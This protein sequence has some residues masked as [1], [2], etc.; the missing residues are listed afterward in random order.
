MYILYNASQNINEYRYGFARVRIIGIRISKSLLYC[1]GTEPSVLLYIGILVTSTTTGPGGSVV[2][3]CWTEPSLSV[4]IGIL[5]TS[6]TTGP[7]I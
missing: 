7:D 3:P 1:V 5:V 6:T 2:V 4:Y